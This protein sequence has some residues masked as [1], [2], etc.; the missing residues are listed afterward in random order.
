MR[1]AEAE[2]PEE[3]RVR[4]REAVDDADEEFGVAEPTEDRVGVV[5]AV[6]EREAVEHQ[7]D[8]RGEAVVLLHHHCHAEE[9]AGDE[10]DEE[11]EEH[12][13]HPFVKGEREVVTFRFHDGEDEDDDQTHG[14]E[15][16][17][18]ERRDPDLQG[19][20]Q[21]GIS[22]EIVEKGHVRNAD[23]G[24]RHERCDPCQKSYHDDRPSANRLETR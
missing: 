19:G 16:E 22:L 11:V 18:D 2:E 5:A 4:H 3:E 24:C 23:D 12:L 21:C 15:D 7:H 9:A 20:V 17:R 8:G 6:D 10:R 1:H 14:E 13:P